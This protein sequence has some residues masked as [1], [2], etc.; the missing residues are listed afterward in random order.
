M[1]IDNFNVAPGANVNI[2]SDSQVTILRD[3]KPQI[4]QKEDVQVIQSGDIIE[5]Q[6]I[7]D[8][9][10]LE[11]IS[12]GMSSFEE[13]IDEGL[14]IKT[15]T[16]FEWKLSKVLLAYFCGKIYC[17]DYVAKKSSCDAIWK[18]EAIGF[19]PDKILSRL[20]NSPHLGA[21]RRKQ[22]LGTAPTGYKKIDDLF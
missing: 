6:E 19:F 21:S 15:P 18:T 9:E 7:A 22:L 8:E 17:G 2:I 11:I 12:K 20:F 1:K 3:E 16:G 14:M 10:E 4:T 13:A 5:P